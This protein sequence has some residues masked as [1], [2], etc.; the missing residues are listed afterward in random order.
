MRPF[1]TPFASQGVPAEDLTLY[2]AT[3]QRENKVA[4]AQCVPSCWQTAL[5]TVRHTF[6]S[7]TEHSRPG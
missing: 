7:L 4:R 3:H 5:A 2:G 6:C 1:W